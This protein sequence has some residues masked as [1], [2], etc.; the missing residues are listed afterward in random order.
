MKI[1]TGTVVKTL[2]WSIIASVMGYVISF[3][4]TPYVTE[5]MGVEA[6]G[7]V[8]LTRT[9]VDYGALITTALNSYA[10]RYIGV[11]YHKKNFEKANQYY[12][13]VLFADFFLS[14][15]IIFL[16]VLF[17]LTIQKTLKVPLYLVDDVRK[18]FV[19]CFMNFSL[20]TIM[21]VFSSA[22]YLKN[23]LDLNY[24]FRT[25]GY[26]A[27]IV[28]L[29]LLFLNCETKLY[30]IGISYI[31]DSMLILISRIWMTKL[32]T[33]ELRINYKLFNIG[34]VKELVVNGI[35]NSINSLG[36]ILNTGLD[37]LITNMMLLPA[38]LGV[39]GVVKTFPNMFVM[40]YQL[41]AQPFQPKLLKSY[42]L[43][44]KEQIKD[45][46]QKAMKTSAYVTFLVYSGFVAVGKSFYKLWLP[47]QD[48]NKLYILTLLALLPNAMEGMLYPCY[49]IY[50]LCVKNKIPCFITIVGGIFN[51]LGM[52]FL[53]KYT[54]I[55]IYA[56]LITTVIIMGITTYVT[57]P[58][59]MSICLQVKWYFFYKI[60]FRG[61]ITCLLMS[62]VM[63]FFSEI[64]EVNSWLQFVFTGFF[65]IC[66]GSIIYFVTMLNKKEKNLVIDKIK[67]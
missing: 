65:S 25:L 34:S 52:Y 1:K 11:E 36:N 26:S 47:G 46:L 20:N 51:M 6:Y 29:I 57:N 59:Y 49:Y 38:D 31:V 23:K 55:Q 50:T 48:A 42:S 41:V 16:S 3:F 44:E 22:A 27:E 2:F 37:L 21:A 24:F 19:L 53:I 64:F 18:L 35:W 60:I 5:T 14:I 66:I 28:S 9:F 40:L 7:Y 63:S 8:T 58:I 43:G 39:L 56:V 12:N 33:P 17:S 10:V 13:S 67:R 32:Y 45:T 15:L 61:S 54:S 30:Y 62:L 4:L